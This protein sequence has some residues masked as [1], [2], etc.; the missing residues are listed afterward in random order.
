[1]HSS[2]EFIMRSAHEKHV[3]VSSNDM[4]GN[5]PVWGKYSPH[6]RQIIFTSESVE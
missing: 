2:V 6:L 3:Y 5:N 4:Y 1:M